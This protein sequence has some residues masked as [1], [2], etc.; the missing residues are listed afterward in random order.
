M[1][2]SSSSPLV[3]WVVVQRVY[4]GVADEIF[5]NREKWKHEEAE[6]DG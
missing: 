5:R 3:G 1:S 2:P 6:Y 4:D